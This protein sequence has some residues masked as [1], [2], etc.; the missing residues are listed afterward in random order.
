[1]RIF[2]EHLFNQH[3]KIKTAFDHNNR[4]NPGKICT[5]IESEDSLVSVDSQKRSCFDKQI[6]IDVKTSFNNAMTCNG[7]RYALTTTKIHL[8]VRRIK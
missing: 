6:S 7:N 2:G 8:C 3:N 4:I 1:M 5:P